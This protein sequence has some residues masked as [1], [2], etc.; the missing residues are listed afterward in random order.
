M[1][2]LLPLAILLLLIPVAF[3]A[4]IGVGPGVVR[5]KDVLFGGYAER[6]IKITNPDPYPA[7]VEIEPRGEI[8]DWI[9]FKPGNNF[10]IPPSSTYTA[11]AIVQPPNDIPAGTYKG[12]LS[13]TS[14]PQRPADVTGAFGVLIQSGAALKVE[15]SITS[16]E[17]INYVGKVTI[18]DT[19]IDLPIEVTLAG[20]NYGNVRVK[21]LLVLEIMDR[22]Q[23]QILRTVE[24]QGSEVL[25]T[26]EKTDVFS[27]SSENLSEGQYWVNATIY[28]NDEVV[29]RQLLTFDVMAKGALS[30]K[31][32][33]V[34][35]INP[36]WIYL[37]DIARIDPVFKNIGQTFVTGKFKGEVYLGDKLIDLLESE[38]YDVPVG[39]TVNLTVYY[40][41]QTSGRHVIKGQVYYSKKVTY[42]KESILNVLP[43]KRPYAFFFDNLIWFVALAIVIAVVV[44]R[45]RLFHY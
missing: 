20:K 5:F 18:R 42:P 7:L 31:G 37:G 25:P 3:A 16:Q 29:G 6:Q 30:V 43:A 10:T 41:P 1:A 21:P 35:I 13:I 28:V 15:L 39:E 38:E 24:L 14:T 8:A 40:K 19:E 26:T 27:V 36:V 23:A 34:Q 12:E 2:K 22:D 45:R 4:G 44:F 9:S 33:L 17:I 32:E 11:T